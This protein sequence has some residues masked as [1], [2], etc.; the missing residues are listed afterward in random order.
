[1]TGWRIGWMLV[2]ER[3]RRAGRR[4]H[5][6]LHDLPAGDRPAR[7]L[8]A[9]DDASYAELDGHV[10]R[11]AD[12]RAAAARRPAPAGDH[13][14]GAGRRRV[15]R[16]R[17]RR[18]PD[19]RLDGVLPRPAGQHRRGRRARA[20][21]STPR[22]AAGSSGSASPGGARTSRSASSDFP[23]PRS[24]TFLHSRTGDPPGER[25]TRGTMYGDTA[26]S[27]PWPTALRDRAD[28]I[29]G[30]A[31]PARRRGRPSDALAGP[32]RPTRCATTPARG[33]PHCVAPPRCTTT[34]PSP[35]TGTLVRSTA[36]KDLIAPSSRMAAADRSSRYESV[37]VV[38]VG[39]VRRSRSRRLTAPSSVCPSGLRGCSRSPRR[40]R[41][42]CRRSVRRGL[43]RRSESLHATRPV[44][45]RTAAAAEPT[46]KDRR[47]M[48]RA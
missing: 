8:A 31:A 28:E 12:N 44:I 37:P 46:R 10:A 36:L 39:L 41:P 25:R 45:A 9:F 16:V 4:A 48:P 17:R 29:P 1:M 2:P 11:Y 13:R 18:P 14:A 21:T 42:A 20:S 3:L 35:S 38:L 15:L 27:G 5:R 22:T 6:Q 43:E 47:R 32:G 24:L 33:R 40:S 23:Q 26:R 7:R 34:P 19:R 30:L